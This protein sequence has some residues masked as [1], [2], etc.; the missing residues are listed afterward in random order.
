LL[1]LYLFLSEYFLTLNSFRLISPRYYLNYFNFRKCESECLKPRPKGC[2]HACLKPCHPGPCQPC[3]QMMKIWCNCGITQLYVK[4]GPWVAASEAEKLVMSCCKDQCP[5]LISCGHRYEFQKYNQCTFEW[6][7]NQRA[8]FWNL[9]PVKLKN[10]PCL[11]ET[12]KIN[13]QNLVP[14]WNSFWSPDPTI[15]DDFYKIDLIKV[16]W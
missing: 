4:C 12:A 10:L 13:A 8:V 3:G 1:C 2:N 5:K 6:L 11:T 15:W 7:T 16:I 14:V 9:E